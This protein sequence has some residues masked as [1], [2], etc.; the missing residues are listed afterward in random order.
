MKDATLDQLFERANRKDTPVEER[1]SS[2]VLVVEELGK[3]VANRRL[4]ALLSGGQGHAAGARERQLLAEVAQLKE[5]LQHLQKN[6]TQRDDFLEKRFPEQL[7]E[8]AIAYSHDCGVD[9]P[10][11]RAIAR[12]TKLTPTTVAH[13]R[14]AIGLPRRQR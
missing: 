3:R 4:S 5:Q 14:A 11:D 6:A 8:A 1:R 9:D 2:A 10:S 7:V 13:V 12:L